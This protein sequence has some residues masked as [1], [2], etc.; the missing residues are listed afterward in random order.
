MDC[1]IISTFTSRRDLR[2]RQLE[3]RL[4]AAHRVRI[5]RRLLTPL[6]HT[7]LWRHWVCALLL[8]LQISL[9]LQGLLLVRCH[10]GLRGCGLAHALLHGLWHGWCGG[11][12]LFGRVDDGF[13]VGAVSVGGLGRVQAGL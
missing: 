4:A 13:A 6:M 9:V 10:V 1:V 8:L 3:L 7:L 11:V 12:L 2:I 5:S